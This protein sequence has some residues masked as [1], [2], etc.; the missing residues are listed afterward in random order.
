[1]VDV[2]PMG[3]Q[4]Y[5]RLQRVWLCPAAVKELN[6]ASEGLIVLPEVLNIDEKLKAFSGMTPYLRHIPDKDPP[7]GHLICETTIKAPSTQKPFLLNCYPVQQHH[8]PTMLEFFKSAV[9]RLD[10]GMMKNTIIVADAYYISAESRDWLRECDFKYLL[11]VNPTRFQEVW[12]VL[13]SQVE[14]IGDWAVAWS[15][16]TQEAA[17]MHWHETL[18]MK[19]ILTNAFTYVDND[20]PI[21]EPPFE[22]YYKVTFNI[23]DHLN[24]ALH[25]RGYP[26]VRPGWMYNFDDFHF[27]ALLWNSYV[28]YLE[29][30]PTLGELDWHDYCIQLSKELWEAKR[31]K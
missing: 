4:R 15:E 7:N 23:S 25:G 16:E 22:R 24:Q 30:N 17:L 27:A 29:C 31:A 14:K 19:Y 20:I 12:V 8:G 13:A 10:S 6:K 5:K 26:Y 28:L 21:A 3:K 1:M 9:G 2:L 11:A 18:G